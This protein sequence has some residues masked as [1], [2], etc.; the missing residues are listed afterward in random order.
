M[1]LWYRF[2]PNYFLIQHLLPVVAS[3]PCPVTSFSARPSSSPSDCHLH[4]GMTSSREHLIPKSIGWMEWTRWCM[5]Q[6]VCVNLALLQRLWV[7]SSDLWIPNELVTPRQRRPR[8][9]P[10]IIHW[11]VAEH[12][13]H[14]LLVARFVHLLR[15]PWLAAIRHGVERHSYL[16]IIVVWSSKPET[17][18]V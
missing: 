5:S 2:F 13:M 14:F 7:G 8:T 1:L 4:I 9:S 10:V 6:F 18:L 12:L 11:G 17:G 15:I 16:Q 3:S